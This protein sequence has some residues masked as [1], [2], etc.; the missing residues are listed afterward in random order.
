M[1]WSL[2][3][4]LFLFNSNL[5]KKIVFTFRT[6]EEYF[7]YTQE[8]HNFQVISFFLEKEL[9]MCLTTQVAYFAVIPPTHAPKIWNIHLT[10]TCIYFKRENP[11]KN[12]KISQIPRQESLQNRLT[13]NSTYCELQFLSIMKKNFSR[14]LT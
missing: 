9:L 7:I 2:H 11:I 3:F 12:E 5:H 4:D 6:D 14:W 1:N 10:I 8:W 13:V